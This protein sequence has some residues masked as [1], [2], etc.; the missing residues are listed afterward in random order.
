MLSVLTSPSSGECEPV[1]EVPLR[2][3]HDIGVSNAP[4]RL[5]S[6]PSAEAT[7]AAGFPHDTLRGSTVDVPFERRLRDDGSG[8]AGGKGKVCAPD[9]TCTTRSR[10]WR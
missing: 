9:V 6:E 2:F 10:A 1:L 3:S 4:P 5:S 8:M 7:D